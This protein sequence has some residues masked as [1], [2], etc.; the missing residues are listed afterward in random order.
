MEPSSIDD[1][2]LAA[3]RDQP[4]VLLRQQTLSPGWAQ[5]L[6]KNVV[7]IGGPVVVQ[8][9]SIGS[10]GEHSFEAKQNLGQIVMGDDH[11]PVGFLPVGTDLAEKHIGR[12]ADRAGEA[13][14]DLVAQRV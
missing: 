8:G 4:L 11:Q 3:S 9:R 6:A 5:L 12:D 10:L 13:L 2:S 1:R 7:L 14:A